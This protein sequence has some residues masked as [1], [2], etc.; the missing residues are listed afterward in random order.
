MDYIFEIVIFLI[1]ISLGFFVGSWQEKKHFKSIRER[2]EL[3]KDIVVIPSRNP[4]DYNQYPY[5]TELICGSVVVAMDYFKKV[6]G[7]LASIFGGRIRFYETLVERARRE[8]VLRLKQAAKDQNAQMVFNI[9]FSTASILKNKA[10]QPGG[11]VEVTAY[12]TAIIYNR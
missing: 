6:A 2:E 4:P 12:G 10:G 7:S 11:S 8:A 3:L 1:L 9:K 5:R